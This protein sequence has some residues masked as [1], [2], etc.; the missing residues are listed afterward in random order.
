M[1]LSEVLQGFDSTR[2]ELFL[3]KFNTMISN[4]SDLQKKKPANPNATPTEPQISKRLAVEVDKL[5]IVLLEEYLHSRRKTEGEL[6]DI[7]LKKS[8]QPKG[9]NRSLHS[10]LF[11]RRS[12]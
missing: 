1:I 3:K 6:S 9:K 12:P 10:R 11:F 8:G 7:F 2:K 4:F 5:F